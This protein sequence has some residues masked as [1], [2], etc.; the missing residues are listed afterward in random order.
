MLLFLIRFPL[1][2]LSNLD[3]FQFQSHI[4]DSSCEICRSLLYTFVFTIIVIHC[5]EG[6]LWKLAYAFKN[7]IHELN[8]KGWVEQ[9]L[10]WLNFLIRYTFHVFLQMLTGEQIFIE[11]HM[12]FERARLKYAKQR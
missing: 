5:S 3:L 10:D 2:K 8:I 4:A 6:H 7:N 9:N 1:I 11:L 12:D